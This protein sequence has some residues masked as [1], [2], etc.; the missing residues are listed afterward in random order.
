MQQVCSA[1]TSSEGQLKA[2]WQQHKAT[3]TGL[4]ELHTRPP[5]QERQKGIVHITNA[6]NSGMLHALAVNAQPLHP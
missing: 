5:G 6:F 2:Q 1:D 4:L 3:N